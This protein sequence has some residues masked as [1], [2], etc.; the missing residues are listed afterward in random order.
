MVLKGAH[1]IHNIQRQVDV[2]CVVMHYQCGWLTVANG[3]FIAH[4]AQ[5]LVKYIY[6]LFTNLSDLNILELL[7]FSL[8]KLLINVFN[9]RIRD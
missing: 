6:E 8:L 3:S 2:V 9:I 7:V 4:I 1:H 5:I